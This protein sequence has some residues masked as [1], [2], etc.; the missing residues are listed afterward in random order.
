MSQNS[1]VKTNQFE[2]QSLVI[3]SP[4]QN[5]EIDIRSIFEELNIFDKVFAFLEVNSFGEQINKE[6]AKLIKY[7]SNKCSI[8][9]DIT[10]KYI[11]ILANHP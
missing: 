4:N 6:I 5:I 3:L 2:I 7:V 11:K 9:V 10:D 8:I 1:I